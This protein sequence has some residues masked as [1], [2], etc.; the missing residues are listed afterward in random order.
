MPWKADSK[1]FVF[2]ICS[3]LRKIL[4]N[5][6][7]IS[8]VSDSVVRKAQLLT[9]TDVTKKTSTCLQ[10]Q[11]FSFKVGQILRHITKIAN[12]KEILHVKILSVLDENKKIPFWE[13]D[14]PKR[15]WYEIQ[16]LDSHFEEMELFGGLWLQL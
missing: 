7:T 5:M 2:E 14:D 4:C 3:L 12:K 16:F 15:R 6:G 1:K 11:K 10:K 9:Q 8:F 13:N